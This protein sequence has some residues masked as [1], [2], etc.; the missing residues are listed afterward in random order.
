MLHC[1]RRTV[2]IEWAE[3]HN[4]IENANI[5]HYNNHALPGFWLVGSPQNVKRNKKK[6]RMGIDGR[7]RDIER[8]GERVC[9][10]V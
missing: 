5:K 6:V 9:V 3:S 7:G 1:P 10:C 8:E 2:W 4:R